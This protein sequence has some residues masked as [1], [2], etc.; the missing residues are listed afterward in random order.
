MNNQLKQQ[1]SEFLDDQLDAQTALNLLREIQDDKQLALTLNRYA[2]IGH[3]LKNTPPIFD[4]GTF[5]A[6]V[7]A[8]IQQEPSYLLPTQSKQTH[9]PRRYQVLAAAASVALVVFLGTQTLHQPTTRESVTN[10]ALSDPKHLTTAARPNAKEA[11]LAPLNE[12]IHDYLQ[13]HNNGVY[14]SSDPGLHQAAKVT[15]YSK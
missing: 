7:S 4:D 8:Q 15:A 5:L 2:A 12:R 9:E 1:L 13:A 11:E 6:A 10:V 14:T 3:A